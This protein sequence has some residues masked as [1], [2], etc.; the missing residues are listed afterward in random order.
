MGEDGEE[1]REE[2]GEGG[3]EGSSFRNQAPAYI[4]T[5]TTPHTLRPFPI[6]PTPTPP[7]PCS[8][9]RTKVGPLDL[10]NRVV[11][12]LMLICPLCVQPKTLSRRRATCTTCTLPRTGFRHGGD[13][14][15]FHPT[16]GVVAVDFLKT[17]VDDILL[18]VFWGGGG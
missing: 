1:D 5:P 2:D 15:G 17:S 11:L 13:L 8:R 14:Q 10:W 12:H 18:C 3:G 9:T 4:P 16:A 6:V 7:P